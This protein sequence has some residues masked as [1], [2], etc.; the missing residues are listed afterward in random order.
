MADGTLDSEKLTLFDNWDGPVQTT[1]SPPQDIFDGL[2]GAPDHNVATERVPVGT[3]CAIYNHTSTGKKGWSTLIYLQ[4]VANAGVAIA[5]KQFLVRDVAAYPYRVTNDP[6]DALVANTELGSLPAAVALSAITTTYYGW[7]WCGGQ[8]PE[9]LV[10]GM[11]GDYAT[12]GTVVAG[13]VA[14]GNLAA[15]A[16]GLTKHVDT[17]ASLGRF[18]AG[19]AD[20]DDS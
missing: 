15:D 14:L 4:A 18:I 8:A 17:T 2:S 12:D 1:F 5:A 10:S 7:F 3:K 6:D 19:I 20:T 13:P 16:I 11:G 9:F